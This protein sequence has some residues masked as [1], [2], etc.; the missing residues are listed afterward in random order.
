MVRR[1]HTE[2]LGPKRHNNQEDVQWPAVVAGKNTT[3]SKGLKDKAIN[4]YPVSPAKI[5]QALWRK[6]SL[7]NPW[8]LLQQ[9]WQNLTL[10]YGRAETDGKKR[11]SWKSTQGNQMKFGKRHKS[12][13]LRTE[14]KIQ[15]SVTWKESKWKHIVGQWEGR[16]GKWS[17]LPSPMTWAES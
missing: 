15:N 6:E 8:D 7:S 2:D 9:E 4:I 14:K 11:Q 5:K 16:A 17:L 10:C 3:N 12:I 13:H 1:S